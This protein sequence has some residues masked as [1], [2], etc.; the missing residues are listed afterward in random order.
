MKNINIILRYMVFTI[1]LLMP[2]IVLLWMVFDWESFNQV[3][4][5]CVYGK[6]YEDTEFHIKIRNY[7]EK[8]NN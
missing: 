7:Y 4:E 6:K 1:L 2:P 5:W 8:K 3:L